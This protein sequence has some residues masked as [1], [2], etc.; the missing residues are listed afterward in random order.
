MRDIIGGYPYEVKKTGGKVI[1]KFFH[2]GE[3]VK[4]P[5]AVK[6]TLELTLADIKKISKL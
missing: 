4:H 6:M 5:D 2:K 3:N 1:I